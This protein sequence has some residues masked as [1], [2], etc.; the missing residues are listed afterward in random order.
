MKITCIVKL[1]E[2]SLT[3]TPMTQRASQTTLSLRIWFYSK[4]WNNNVI[5][6]AQTTAYFES[7]FF[8]CMQRVEPTIPNSQNSKDTILGHKTVSAIAIVV[9][10]VHNL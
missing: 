9:G 4:S 2:L 5:I 10:N 7:P 1:P 3:C 6:S 8:W